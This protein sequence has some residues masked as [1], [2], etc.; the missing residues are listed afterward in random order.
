[1]YNEELKKRFLDWHTN[2]ETGKKQYELS[3]N[4]FEKYEE[5]WG[6]DL[7]TRSTEELQPVLNNLLGMRTRGRVSRLAL[8][9]AYVKWCLENNVEGACDGLLH[10]KVD[11][12]RIL[13]CKMVNSPLHLQSYLDIICAK[14]SQHT[15]DDTFRCYLWLAY[16]G[17]PEEEIFDIKTSDVDFENFVIKSPYSEKQREYPIYLESLQAFKNCVELDQFVYFHPNY[18]REILRQRVPG[19]QLLKGIK[20][21]ARLRQMRVELSRKSKK[22]VEEGKTNMRISYY[23]AWLS[24]VFYRMYRLELVGIEPDFTEI[25]DEFMSGKTYNLSSGRNLI[26]AKQRRVAKEYMEDYERWKSA[27][28]S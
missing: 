10:V 3:F 19:K 15:I 11:D 24:G 2:S 8:Y 22:A 13:K 17:C 20:T 25:A 27:F 28:F 12:A 5:E 14:E 6:A 16:A 26:G 23:R 9:R 7:C 18:S 1:M 21:E 4:A